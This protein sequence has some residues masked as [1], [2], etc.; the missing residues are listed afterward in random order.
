MTKWEYLVIV[1]TRNFDHYRANFYNSTE[2][3]DWKKNPPIPEYLNELGQQGWELVSTLPVGETV[4]QMHL[5]LKRPK[6]E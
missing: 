2:L 1:C 6:P 5:F 4:G 3:K